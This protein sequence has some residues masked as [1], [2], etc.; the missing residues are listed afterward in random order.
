MGRPANTHMIEGHH[1]RVLADGC[2]EWLLTKNHRGYGLVSVLDHSMSAPRWSYILAN[3]PI[4][5]GLCVCHRC[6]SRACVNPAHL[7]L[8]TQRDNCQDAV[9]K[10]RNCRGEGHGM[11]KLNSRQVSV[12]RHAAD[13]GTPQSFLAQCFGVSQSTIQSV[14]SKHHW[15]S[16]EVTNARSTT[17]G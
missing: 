5:G 1:Y 12:I 2:W 13:F 4:P 15:Q 17:P 7:W 9:A 16:L 3:G 8:G 6:D 14:T 11:A 10:G